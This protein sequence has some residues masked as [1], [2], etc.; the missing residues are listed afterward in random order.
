MS[1]F[2]LRS[3]S[4]D[5]ID[6]IWP[7][8]AYMHQLILTRSRLGLLGISFFCRFITELW[9]LI[10]VRI[11]FLLNI[12][13]TENYWMDFDQILHMYRSILTTSRLGLI[14]IFFSCPHGASIHN[15]TGV[16]KPK[17]NP[18]G[19][20]CC[21]PMNL[22]EPFRVRV[23]YLAIPWSKNMQRILGTPICM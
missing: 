3:I 22:T 9:S 11:S 2:R 4:W 15:R 19:P 20:V 13:R 23:W 1:E 12:L 8:F 21:L 5:Q 10:D 17:W 18:Q 7:N 14:N 6:G 16:P